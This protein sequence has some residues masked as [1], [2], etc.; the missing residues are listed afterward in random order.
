M[1]QLRKNAPKKIAPKK[2]AEVN[3]EAE[4]EEEEVP[5]VEA[6]VESQEEENA[7]EENAPEEK[8]PEVPKVDE[9]EDQKKTEPNV[10]IKLKREIRTTIGNKF[11]SFRA[12]EITSV[13]R[14]VKDIL[15]KAGY[16]DII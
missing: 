9:K 5:E 7:P 2:D 11:Y 3:K 12:G 13:P 4:Q 14:H 10:R 15:A 16:L 8:A 6:E 1:A